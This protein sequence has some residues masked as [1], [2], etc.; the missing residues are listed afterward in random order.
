MGRLRALNE[1]ECYLR[2]YGPRGS[3]GAVRIVKKVAVTRQPS[4]TGERIRQSFE[5]ALEAREPEAA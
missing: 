4:L 5:A 2:C 1:A 3:D